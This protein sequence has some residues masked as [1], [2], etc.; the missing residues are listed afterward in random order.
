LHRAAL[1]DNP[2]LVELLLK[3]GADP[4][5]ICHGRK[6]REMSWEPEVIAIFD[7]FQRAE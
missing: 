1:E 5:A 6:P 2:Q 7:R 4:D 3:H